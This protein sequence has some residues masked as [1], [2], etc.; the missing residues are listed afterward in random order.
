MESEEG[1]VVHF[2]GN[3]LAALYTPAMKGLIEAV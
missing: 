2:R 1:K 3:A